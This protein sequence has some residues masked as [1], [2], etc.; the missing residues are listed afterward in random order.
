[1]L[2]CN[3]GLIQHTGFHTSTT[4]TCWST[5]WVSPPC[6]RDTAT[7]CTQRTSENI[8]FSLKRFPPADTDLQNRRFRTFPQKHTQRNFLNIIKLDYQSRLCALCSKT[9]MRETLLVNLKAGLMLQ[10]GGHM[11][12]SILSIIPI[13]PSEIWG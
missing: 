12:D 7:I 10:N 3:K 8:I 5:V 9:C 4:E 6:G 11:L 13:T 1:M 2:P